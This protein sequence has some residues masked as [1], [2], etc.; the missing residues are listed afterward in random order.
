MTMDHS[1]AGLPGFFF[2]VQ[3]TLVLA[4]VG[5]PV[6]LVGTSV[7]WAARRGGR[8]PCCFAPAFLP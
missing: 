7:W 5:V 1:G 6:L 8:F 2:W 4:Y 3:A